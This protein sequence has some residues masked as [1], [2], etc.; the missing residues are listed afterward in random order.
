MEEADRVADRIAVIDHG[1]IVANDTP[2]ALKTAAGAANLEDAFISLTGRAI[3]EE[4]ANSS[5]QMR[6]SRKMWGRR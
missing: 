5:D 4:E 6:L 1:R 3:R 2:A